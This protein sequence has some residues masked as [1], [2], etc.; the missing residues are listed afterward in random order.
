MKDNTKLLEK[1]S[2]KDKK[3]NK[4]IQEFTLQ[5][6]EIYLDAYIKTHNIIDDM[7]LTLTNRKIRKPNIPSEITENIVRF[8]LK[9]I[10][11]IDVKW[12]IKGCDL[13]WDNKIIEV[14]G[15][16]SSGPNSFGPNTKWDI[17]YFV[18]ALEFKNK[19]F[20]VYEIHLS[21]SSN[22]FRNIKLNKKDT[23]GQIADSNRRG[24]L[25][26]CFYKQFKPQLEEYCELI[27][28]GFISE[29]Y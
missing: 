23:Y 26:G 21:N 25:R 11:N 12:D 15:F 7:N 29:L 6:L 4:I 2:I 27:F 16:S 1:L 18:D 17:L 20:K 8:V 24:K 13:L 9:K 10:K 28:D 3:L 14:K 5:K 19:K 22:I